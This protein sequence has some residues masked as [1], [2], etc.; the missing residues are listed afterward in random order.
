MEAVRLVGNDRKAGGNSVSM[1]GTT[2][3]HETRQLFGQ[4]AY[5]TPYKK[6]ATGRGVT[7]SDY[8]QECTN[9]GAA[10]TGETWGS[11]WK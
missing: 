5:Q 3:C 7:T 1:W 4:D 9:I 2:E 8:G 11:D 6:S 10:E